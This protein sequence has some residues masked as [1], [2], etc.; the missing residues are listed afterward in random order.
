MVLPY[1]RIGGGKFKSALRTFKEWLDLQMRVRYGISIV[2]CEHHY[3]RHFWHTMVEL[4]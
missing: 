2:P 1:L 3:T 4:F